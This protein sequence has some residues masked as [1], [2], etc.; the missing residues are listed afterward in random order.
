MWGQGVPKPNP[1]RKRV[2][3]EPNPERKRVGPCVSEWA[4][5]SRESGEAGALTDMNMKPE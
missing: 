5:A 4:F 2:E 3:G 1:E